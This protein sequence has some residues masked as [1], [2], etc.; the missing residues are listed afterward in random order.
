MKAPD[1][2][3]IKQERRR[4]FRDMATRMECRPEISV[5]GLKDWVLQTYEKASLALLDID[6]SYKRH[7]TLTENVGSLM[8]QS[9]HSLIHILLATR[10]SHLLDLT[11]W[12]FLERAINDIFHDTWSIFATSNF[13]LYHLEIIRSYGEFLRPKEARLVRMEPYATYSEPTGRGMKIVAEKINFA[14]PTFESSDSEGEEPPERK[15]ILNQLSFTIE[16]GEFVAV[17]GGNGSGK[18]TLLKL[19]TRMYDVTGGS[20]QINDIDIRRYDMEELWS[21]MSLIN[22]DYGVFILSKMINGRTV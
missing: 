7:S 18:S 16:P 21:H 5:F 14:Y 4:Y 22:Q 17:I 9:T 15:S 10:Y 12:G 6:H 19:L 8:R 11:T 2:N 3:N 13:V 20:L 1:E